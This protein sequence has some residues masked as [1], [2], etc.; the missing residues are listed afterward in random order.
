[1]LTAGRLLRR[2]L[3]AC[4]GI[5]CSGVVSADRAGPKPAGGRV[6]VNVDADAV[7]IR[8]ASCVKDLLR[9]AIGYDD[10]CA[11]QYEAVCDSG[12]LVQVVQYHADRCAMHVREVTDQ[13]EEFHLVAEIEVRRRLVE[14]EYSGLLRE[15]ARQPDPLQ[16]PTGQFIRRPL[17]KARQPRHLQRVRD[18]G[19][20]VRVLPAEAAAVRV[21]SERHQVADP[22]ATRDRPA[23]CEQRDLPGKRLRRQR[24]TVDDVHQVCGTM[25]L[26]DPGA[27]GLQPRDGPQQRRLTGPIRTNKRRHRPGSELKG[28]AMDNVLAVVAHGQ[29]ASMQINH[30]LRL[31]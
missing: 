29:L 22:K 12:G 15:A 6:V 24:E 10:S 14:Q 3:S 23:L 2:R 28:R 30:V 8:Q 17:S 26:H 4:W 16:L 31:A 13:V 11:E 19:L 21:P 27:C 7:H 9:S 20:P 5:G 25:Q 1:V 18:D